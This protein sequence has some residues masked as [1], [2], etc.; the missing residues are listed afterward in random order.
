MLLPISKLW[1]SFVCWLF[2][3]VPDVKYAKV[4]RLELS[5]KK[6]RQNLNVKCAKKRSNLEF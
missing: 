1:T 5:A 3:G 4:I 2:L 6:V